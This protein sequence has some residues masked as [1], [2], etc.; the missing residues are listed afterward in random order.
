MTD[1]PQSLAP[2]ASRGEPA[3]RASLKWLLAAP[4]RIAFTLGATMLVVCSVWWTGAV[5]AILSGMPPRT[6]IPT[7]ELHGLVMVFGFM[8]FFFTGF[9]FTAV[10]KWLGARAS[11]TRDVGVGLGAQAAGW[12]V[13]FIGG[14]ST[15]EAFAATLGG[16][17]LSAVAFG[18]TALWL[19]FISLIR[20]SSLPDR[21]H[22]IALAASAGVGVAALWTAA[23]G[24]IESWHPVVNA[25]TQIGLWMFVGSTFVT[26]AHRMIPFMGSTVLAKLDAWHPSWLLSALLGLFGVEALFAATAAASQ[27]MNPSL[28]ATRAAFELASGLGLSGLA[29]QWAVRLPLRI[30]MV[31]MLHAAF[32]WLAASFVLGG[33]AHWHATVPGGDWN[34]AALHAFTMGFLGSIL[35]AMLT[36]IVCAQTGRSVVADDLLWGLFGLL[37]GA[38]VLRLAASL[39]AQFVPRWQWP[40]TA[41]GAALWSLPWLLWARRYV[42][43]LTRRH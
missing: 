11:T 21:S 3:P 5:L 24:L 39:A 27:L 33:L 18:S 43:W 23:V 38:V 9:L 19:Q 42:P 2:S 31:A 34:A 14:R 13:F 28:V 4:H 29:W 26:A 22:A 40:L 25:A 17:G 1:A 7:I 20:S 16:A 35:L 6:A 8:P 12:V 41:A 15:D 10:P 32:T 37:Q 30:R 36:R